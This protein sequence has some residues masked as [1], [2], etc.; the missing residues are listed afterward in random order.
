VL[1]ATLAR[2]SGHDDVDRLQAAER[3]PPIRS[4]RRCWRADAGPESA[5]RSLFTALL[6]AL[7]AK[8]AALRK[9]VSLLGAI[10]LLLCA[11]LL[12]VEVT[13]DGRQSV[14]LGNWPLPYAIEIAADLLS[15]ALVLITAL[16]EQRAVV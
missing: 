12:F 5:A 7:L 4:S 8:H 9:G 14:A 15:A 3:R 13:Q 2:R 1:G 16:L 11:I 6:T 10:V